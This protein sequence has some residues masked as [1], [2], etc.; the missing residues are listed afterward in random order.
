[1]YTHTHTH[2]KTQEWQSTLSLCSGGAALVIEA[3]SWEG[4][5]ERRTKSFGFSGMGGGSFWPDVGVVG[6]V[7]VGVAGS[8]GS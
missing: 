8:G 3:G 5:V 6:A 7:A 2:A 4:I 1:M